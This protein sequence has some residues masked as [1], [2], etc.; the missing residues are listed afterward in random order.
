MFVSI[1]KKMV[2]KQV[3]SFNWHLLASFSYLLG[4]IHVIQYHPYS[5]E[6]VHFLVVTIGKI[7]IDFR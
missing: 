7:N 1:L 6:L 3:T 5:L 2:T 4:V